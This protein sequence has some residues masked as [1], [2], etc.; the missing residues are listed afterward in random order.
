[1]CKGW[2]PFTKFLMEKPEDGG[3]EGDFSRTKVWFL[4]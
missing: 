3:A 1:V 2:I 4:F